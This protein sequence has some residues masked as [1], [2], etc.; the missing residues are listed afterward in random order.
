QNELGFYMVDQ[1]AAQE[2][3]KYEFFRDKLAETNNELQSLLIRIT[4][5]FTNEELIFIK[6]NEK[7]LNDV[8]LF[9]EDFGHQ[10]LAIRDVL[11]WFP[12]DTEE[13]IVRDMIEQIIVDHKIY[14]KSIREEVVILMSCKRSIKA[15]NYLDIYDMIYLL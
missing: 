14:V 4:F 8:S 7:L 1:H 11:T 9:F 12:K 6:E 3:I 15:N 10:T 13:E 2:R 5:E